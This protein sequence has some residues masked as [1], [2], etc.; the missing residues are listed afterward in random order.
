MQDSAPFQGKSNS[1][2]LWTRDFIL[3]SL[4]NL[5]MFLGL[6]VLLPT[7]PVFVDYLGGNDSHVGMVIGVFTVSAM[8]IRPWAGFML[9]TKERR[10]ILLGGLAVFVISAIAYNWAATITFLMLMRFLHGLGW[11]A[12]T[13]AAGTVA[14]D[15]IPRPRMGEGMGYFGLATAVSMAV[16]PAA[17]IFIINNYSFTYL[18]FTSA[19]LALLALIFSLGIRYEKVTK[20]V[21]APKPTLFEKSALRPSLVI[22]FVTTTFGSIVSFLVLYANQRGIDN[23]GPYFSVFALIMLVSRPVSGILVDKRGYNIVVVPGILLLVASMLILSVSHTM[24]MFLLAAA[25]YG[26]GFGSVQPS[27]QALA[28]RNAEPNRR[29][30]VNSTFFSAFDLGIGGGAM[31]WGI[32]AQITGYPLIYAIASIPGLIALATYLMLGNRKSNSDSH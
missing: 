21:N 27:M 29:G 25:L 20:D 28:V 30:A 5:T 22:F 1:F 32:V 8:I 2:P 26:L 11:G 4:T 19:T 23:I 16:A 24:W 14:A 18:F 10:G 7:L 12:C 17:G 15:I 9:D 6:Q 3:I 31:V 13:T